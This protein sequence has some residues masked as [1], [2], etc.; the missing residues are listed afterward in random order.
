MFP[1]NQVTPA[2]KDEPPS[3]PSNKAMDQNTTSLPLGFVNKIETLV[4]VLP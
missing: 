2:G 4:E 3:G 1:E